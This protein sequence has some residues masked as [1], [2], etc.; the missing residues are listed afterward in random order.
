MRHETP[1]EAASNDW[2]REYSRFRAIPSTIRRAASRALTQYS[3]LIDL[4]PGQV[5]LDLGCGNGRNAIFA[6]EHGCDVYAIDFSSV[7]AS[8]CQERARVAGVSD[9]VHVYNQSFF[10]PLP[11]Q[12]S[13]CNLILDLY[14]SCHFMSIATREKYVLMMKRHLK[15][16]GKVVSAL[17]SN[18]DE[19]YRKLPRL[20]DGKVVDPAN[21]I[22]KKL[23]DEAEVPHAYQGLEVRHLEVIEFE[24]VVLGQRYRRSVFAAL[25]ANRS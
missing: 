3:D 17:L 22:A 21:D 18:E 15:P 12:E 2:D 10:D 9:R 20:S 16:T 14:I 25:F 7:A 5:V 8:E 11:V 23:F 4:K 6:A 24:D 13:S 19:Y 1:R